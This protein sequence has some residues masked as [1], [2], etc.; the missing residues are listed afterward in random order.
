VAATVGVIEMN[1]R[2]EIMDFED[3]IYTNY[4]EFMV[5]FNLTVYF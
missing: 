2:C 3:N 4:R 1:D 5:D